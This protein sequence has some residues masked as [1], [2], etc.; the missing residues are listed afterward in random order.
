MVY[1]PCEL[2]LCSLHIIHAQFIV[3]SAELAVEEAESDGEE[4]E[5]GEGE[6]E[7]GT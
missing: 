7:D 6:K 5:M 3:I 4:G 1:I 2:N